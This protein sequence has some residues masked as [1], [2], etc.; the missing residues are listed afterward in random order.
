M[1]LFDRLFTPDP[2]RTLE[3]AKKLLDRGE[4]TEAL[5]LARR[6]AAADALTYR[7]RA[8]EVIRRAQE[9]LVDAALARAALAE[10]SE[11]FEDAAEWIRTALEH[12]EDEGRRQELEERAAA[13]LERVAEAEK[14]QK[15]F[16]LPEPD[17]PDEAAEGPVAYVEPELDPDAHYEALVGMLDEDVAERYEERPEPFRRAF[18]Q[19][20]QGQPRGALPALDELVGKHPEDPVYRLERGHC[21]LLVGEF[22]GACED[23]EAVWEAFGDEPLDQGRTYSVPGF[24]AEAMLGRGKPAELLERLNE[25][26]VPPEC[27][28][29]LCYQYAVGLMAVERFEE[30]RG[31]LLGVMSH[32]IQVPD[33]PHLL[34]LALYK[35]G[36]TQAAIDTLERAIAPSCAAG[37]CRRPAMHLPSFRDLTWFYLVEGRELDRVRRLLSMIAQALG[38]QLQREDHLLLVKYHE[39]TGDE[40]AAREAADELRRL[41]EAAR[42]TPAKPTAVGEA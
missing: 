5:R 15:R 31:Y 39:L 40:E 34:A 4:A 35:L 26:A 23:L 27:D 8:E 10:E 25:V 9:I 1:G 14:V 16:V 11:Y 17:S 33:F 21:R 18:L 37:S 42:P 22:E 2:H 13:F 20:N 24:W 36:Q 38:G 29:G 12:V 7:S 32:F 28:H 30:A 19:L 6:A 3:R 41:E